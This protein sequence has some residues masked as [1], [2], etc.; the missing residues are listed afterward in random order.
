MAETKILLLR[1]EGVLQSWGREAYWNDRGTDLMPRKAAV[2]GMIGSA[3][4]L[5]RGDSR[6]RDLSSGL[7]MGIRVDA[8]GVRLTDFQTVTGHPLMTAEGKRRTSDT[9]ISRREYLQDASFLVAL[10]G[11]ADALAQI[12]EALED[13][14]WPVYLGRRCCVPTRPVFETLT[15]EYA[16]VYSA[17]AEYDLPETATRL[18]IEVEGPEPQSGMISLRRDDVSGEWPGRSYGQRRVWRGNLERER[19]P[20]EN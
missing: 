20:D 16:D 14:V 7:T 18:T 11:N 12:A 9:F 6:L 5:S 15:D 19:V 8:H 3:M 13:P 17:L 10:S 1:L 2:I 4:G